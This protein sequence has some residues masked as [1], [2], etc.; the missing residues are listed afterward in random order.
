MEREVEQVSAANMKSAS[1]TKEEEAPVGRERV[2]QVQ[3]DQGAEAEK[4]E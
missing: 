3:D 2:T 4:E 1:K